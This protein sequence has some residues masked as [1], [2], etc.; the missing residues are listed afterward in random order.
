LDVFEQVL[1]SNDKGKGK[2]VG[3]E[4]TSMQK[5]GSPNNLSRMF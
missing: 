5:R 4:K 2:W 3:D 1:P